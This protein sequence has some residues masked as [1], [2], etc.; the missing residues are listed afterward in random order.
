MCHTY[1]RANKAAKD[2][3]SLKQILQ[4]AKTKQPKQK[5]KIHGSYD[6]EPVLQA[7]C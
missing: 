7:N 5:P 4:I 1:S 6:R 3:T 2:Q